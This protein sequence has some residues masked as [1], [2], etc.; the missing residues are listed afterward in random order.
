MMTSSWRCV[1]TASSCGGR[2]AVVQGVPASVRSNGLS[3]LIER[4]RGHGLGVSTTRV[5]RARA[6]LE[7]AAAGTKDLCGWKV[8]AERTNS[9]CE[10]NEE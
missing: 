9:S 3:K 6:F 5:K 8:K 10:T 4:S 7:T 1:S 2:G